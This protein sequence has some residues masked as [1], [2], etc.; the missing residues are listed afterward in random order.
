MKKYILIEDR[1]GH[2]AGTVVYDQ[3]G[4]DYGLSSDDTRCTGV[5]HISV[6]LKSDGDYPGFT[7]PLYQL[8]AI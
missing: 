3:K 2:K 6:T 8:K 5:E 4:W 1:F 7:V